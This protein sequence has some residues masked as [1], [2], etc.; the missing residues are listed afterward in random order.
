[1]STIARPPLFKV[2]RWQLTTLGLLSMFLL[3]LDWVVS[4]SVFIGGMIH[5]VPHAWFAKIAFNKIGASQTDTIV[6][7]FYLGQA[8]K[9]L[10]TAFL[11]F[12][13]F[14]AANQIDVQIVVA[15]FIAMFPLY[16][17]LVTNVLR[18]YS[19]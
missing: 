14:L 8:A 2:A 18:K 4:L 6:A 19:A 12:L 1:M 13:A 7:S 17:T 5:I 3:P 15:S 11:L 9:F 10:L 16:L